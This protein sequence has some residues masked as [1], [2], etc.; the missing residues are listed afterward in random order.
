MFLRVA[1]LAAALPFTAAVAQ[2]PATGDAAPAPA[3]GMDT[4]TAGAR[5]RMRMMAADTDHD[6]RISRAEWLAMRAA[7]PARGGGA[8]SAGGGAGG[9]PRDPGRMFDRLDA[10][11]DGF[12]DSA[13]IDALIQ[14]R[15][16]RMDADGDGRVTRG[17]RHGATPGGTQDGERHD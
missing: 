4:A 16:A 14:R 15:L 5:M 10:N 8:G 7:M 6:G 17:E 2:P 11:A 9:P 13:E 12:L 3:A 1:L